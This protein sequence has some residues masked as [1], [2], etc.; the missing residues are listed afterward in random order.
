M[1]DTPSRRS[2]LR[3]AALGAAGLAGCRARGLDLA[4]G[5]LPL[6]SG[7]T[8]APPAPASASMPTA[9]VGHGSPM[10]MVDPAVGGRW[11]RWA[12]AMPRPRAVLVV[13][14]HWEQHPFTLGTTTTAPLLYDF[15]GF[16]DELYAVKYPA[17][18]APELATEVERLV[19][20]VYAT[21]REPE[22]ALD[23][24][25]FAP[26]VWLYPEADVPVL[27]MSIPSYDP[28]LLFA[29]GRALAPLRQQGV[30]ILGSGNVTHNLRRI[31]RDG[32]GPPAWAAD[33]DAWTADVLTRGDMDALLD[34][35][36]KAPAATTNHPTPDH[37]LPIYVVA[38]AADGAKASFPV[39]GW[40]GGS[41]SRRC[42]QLG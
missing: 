31:G 1:A 5:T 40:E 15:Y 23:H 7:T 35:T 19:R 37:W 34:W 20:P 36:R 13:S 2:V 26:L 14:A 9:F 17:P 4:T 24:G 42:V 28:K 3:W 25:A 16:P 30:L 12:E 32:G 39:T 11:T 10:S 6:A 22:R 33:F 21:D 27:Q 41:L 29:A 8:T 38:G 18:G